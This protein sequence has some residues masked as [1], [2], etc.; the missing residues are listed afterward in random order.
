[1]SINAKMYDNAC[2]KP[3]QSED[4]QLSVEAS[5]SL[6]SAGP[7]ARLT[8]HSNDASKKRRESAAIRSKRSSMT[9]GELGGNK[10]TSK[11]APKRQPKTPKNSVTNPPGARTTKEGSPDAAVQ[12]SN[13]PSMRETGTDKETDNK[14]R[15]C[16]NFLRMTTKNRLLNSFLR[17]DITEYEH[18]TGT[19]FAEPVNF[20][21]LNDQFKSTYNLHLAS[22]NLKFTKNE[23]NTTITCPNCKSTDIIVQYKQLLSGDEVETEIIQCNYCGGSFTNQ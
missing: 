15:A 14:V 7:H 11:A 12:N 2:F 18:I 3:D 9:S 8:E 5:I 20:Y 10:Q 17:E 13:T 1:M 23:K 19:K 4:E 21:Q 6:Q 16:L 22:T